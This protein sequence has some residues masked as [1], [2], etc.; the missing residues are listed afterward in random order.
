MQIILLDFLKCFILLSVHFLVLA[1]GAILINKKMKLPGEIFRKLL[2]IAAVFSIIPIV[3]PSSSWIASVMVCG[4]FQLSAFV[5]TKCMDINKKVNMR[6]RKDGEQLRSMFLLYCTYILLIIVCWGFFN[7]KW[8]AILSV[9]AWGVGDA[10]AAII[11]KRFGM[12]KIKGRFV[13]GVKSVEGTLAM[14]ITSFVSVFLLYFHHT[15]LTSIWLVALVCFWI[16]LFSSISEL[17]SKN[18]LD[19]VICPTVSMAGF[20]ILTLAAGA[21]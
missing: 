11:G 12:H 2:H 8:M 9:V 13:D 21:I 6:E 19:T 5:L 15:S 4:V 18:G 20:T 7:Q 16:A 1:G 10:M 14:F 17:I 3:L